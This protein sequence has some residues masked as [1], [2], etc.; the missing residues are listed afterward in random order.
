M[1]DLVKQLTETKKDIKISMC[2]EIEFQ[3]AETIRRKTGYT[4]TN[5][6]DTYWY[7]D[8]NKYSMEVT[9]YENSVKNVEEFFKIVDDFFNV[10]HREVCKIKNNENE[11]N[12][13]A[14]DRNPG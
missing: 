12:I 9:A 5:D 2:Q 6:F 14:D 13:R 8:V 1:N 11:C 7:V 3:L 4:I 10:D